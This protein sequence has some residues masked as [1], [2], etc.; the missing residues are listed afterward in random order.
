MLRKIQDTMGQS[1]DIMGFISFFDI[2]CSRDFI[3]SGAKR[4]WKDV[5]QSCDIIWIPVSHIDG[6][7][8]NE[9]MVWP[10]LVVFTFFFYANKLC[11]TSSAI[12]VESGSVASL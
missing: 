11:S 1:H 12:C 5:D 7:C 4:F 10:F 9:T 6:F 8:M 3:G 2:Y